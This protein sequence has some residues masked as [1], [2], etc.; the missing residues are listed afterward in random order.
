MFD[1]LPENVRKSEKKPDSNEVPLQIDRRSLLALAVLFGISSSPLSR[2]VSAE[3][4]KDT[5]DE[6]VIL[7][8]PVCSALYPSTV[9]QNT[10]YSDAKV[11]FD[12]INTLLTQLSNSSA[13]GIADRAETLKRLEDQICNPHP[14]MLDRDRFLDLCDGL[15]P[16]PLNPALRLLPEGTDKII[17]TATQLTGGGSLLLGGGSYLLGGTSKLAMR[18]SVPGLVLSGVSFTLGMRKEI[19]EYFN[20]K[21]YSPSQEDSFAFREMQE[22]ALALHHELYKHNKRYKEYVDEVKSK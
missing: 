13:L 16:N 3:D 5:L 17:E 12:A 10:D 19:Y 11:T 20:L 14:G 21:K 15:N 9:L 6:H 4:E 8:G 18:F 1:H 22:G 7:H 2:I